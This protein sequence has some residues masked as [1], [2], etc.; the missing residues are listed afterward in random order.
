ML[1][2]G[3]VPLLQPT[4]ELTAWLAVQMP[5]ADIF[6]F[7]RPSALGNMDPASHFNWFLGRGVRVNTFFNPWGASRWGMAYVLADDAMLA[8]I[9]AKAFDPNADNYQALPF[10]I[11]DSKSK[12]TTN[13][14]MLPAVPLTKIKNVNPRLG[15]WLL[16]LVDDRYFWWEKTATLT[17]EEGVTTW[18]GLYSQIAT[19]LG[20]TLSV[21]TIS[22]DYLFP[23]ASLASL[24][25][26]PLLLDVIASSVGQRV[27]RTLTG[28]IVARSARSA[29]AL[30]T[31][32]VN[33]YR[34]YAGGTFG[35]GHVDG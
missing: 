28:D 5:P 3:N 21:D 29:L 16:V 26:I 35:L 2:Y 18:S 13:L 14:W 33:K 30:Q 12:M 9:T 34:K 11:N 1:S 15:G 17:I 27:V 25:Y 4:A 20:I 8:K 6:S 24:E 10:V 23:S 7:R 19:V 22:A 31:L 32:Q